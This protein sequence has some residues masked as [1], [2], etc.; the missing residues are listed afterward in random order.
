MGMFDSVIMNCECG[1]KVE[2]QSKAGD[3][4]LDVFSPNSVPVVIAADINGET[5][6]C[7]NCNKAYV[8]GEKVENMVSLLVR[9]E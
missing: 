2:W 7:R 6:Y 5:A 3:C 4:H 1:G 9:P 8:I